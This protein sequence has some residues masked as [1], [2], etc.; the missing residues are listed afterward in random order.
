MFIKVI[1]LILYYLSI[2]NISLAGESLCQFL[3]K[4]QID[5]G[6]SNKEKEEIENFVE[7]IIVNKSVHYYSKKDTGLALDI[8]VVDLEN[9]GVRTLI[10]PEER[11][12]SGGGQHFVHKA[13][14]YEQNESI[15]IVG[16]IK[17]FEKNIIEEIFQ[18]TK[19]GFYYG[20]KY[21]QRLLAYEMIQPLYSSN[22]TEFITKFSCEHLDIKS[23]HILQI[24]ISLIKEVKRFHDYGFVHR[25]IK[26]E[27]VVIC[28]ENN[29]L[30]SKLIDFGLSSYDQDPYYDS[31]ALGTLKF[32][33]P[34]LWGG[35]KAS[36]KSFTYED[37]IW[38]LG[39]TLYYLKFNE[40]P[41]WTNSIIG[42]MNLNQESIDSHNSFIELK[43]NLD[44][45]LGQV[46]YNLL[47][48]DSDERWTLEDVLVFLEN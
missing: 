37:D 40:L 19:L 39:L 18:K 1:V 2:Y 6:I 23:E 8:E 38:S 15:A 44:D 5:L 31:T 27:N 10:Y 16:N 45:R 17:E 32:I 3:I 20:L 12:F 29:S 30:S 11:Y 13:L 7:N 34:R 33:S 43:E 47:R 25:D 14:I 41:F 21:N 9:L 4:E 24:G 48:V 42:S 26:P 35:S 22:L 46:I 36:E 28:E